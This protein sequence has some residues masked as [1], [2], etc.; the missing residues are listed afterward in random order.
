MCHAVLGTYLDHATLCHLSEIIA[1]WAVAPSIMPSKVFVLRTWQSRFHCIPPTWN[2][3]PSEF[4]CFLF[5]V[6]KP[7]IK[8]GRPLAGVGVHPLLCPL[9]FSPISP[10][11]S[12]APT[13]CFKAGMLGFRTALCCG[14]SPGPILQCPGGLLHQSKLH[15][16]SAPAPQSVS[17]SGWRVPGVARPCCL[18]G[19]VFATGAGC[20][21][22][23]CG[24]ARNPGQ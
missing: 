3:I 22:R 17:S 12:Q 2:C 14:W 1:P 21:G 24:S 16:P 20:P 10:L 9:T 7:R 23:G 18:G 13:L 11:P 6:S 19:A 8:C 15:P 5:V 4:F